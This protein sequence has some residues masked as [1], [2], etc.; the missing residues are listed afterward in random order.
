VAYFAPETQGLLQYKSASTGLANLAGRYAAA[1]TLAYQTWKSDPKSEFLQS[2]A[3]RQGARFR[4]GLPMKVSSKAILIRPLSLRGNYLADDMEWG[5]AE[6]FARLM[7]S[8]IW[9]RQN[10]MR[11]WQQMNPGWE[12]NKPGIISTIP[13]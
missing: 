4:N 3:S 7:K 12:K 6:L 13:S 5:A 2:D 1:M 11:F 8:D 9:L 10:T